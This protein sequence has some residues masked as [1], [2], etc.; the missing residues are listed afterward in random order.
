MYPFLCYDYKPRGV[1]IHKYQLNQI[2]IT[3]I[4]RKLYT[5]FFSSIDQF[6]FRY[7]FIKIFFFFVN[8]KI[9]LRIVG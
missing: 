8:R 6:I 1:D 7:I 2:I 3:L 9:S 5:Y 4:Q